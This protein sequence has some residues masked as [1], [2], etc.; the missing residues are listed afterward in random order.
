M[1][2]RS[3]KESTNLKTISLN[4]CSILSPNLTTSL[5]RTFFRD[6]LFKKSNERPNIQAHAQLHHY[7]CVC[8]FGT[9]NKESFLEVLM[10]MMTKRDKII[11]SE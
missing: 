10:T 8:V 4:F 5:A 7:A 1:Q 9:W 3:I 2:L 11:D 6:G